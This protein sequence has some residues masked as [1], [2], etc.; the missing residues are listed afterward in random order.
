[1]KRLLTILAAVA[2]IASAVAETR[3]RKSDIDRNIRLFSSVVNQMETNYVDSIDLDNAVETAIA[4]MLDELDPYTEYMPLRAQ[5]SFRSMTTGEYGGIGSYIRSRDGYTYIAGS[6]PGSP[7]MEAGL[8]TGDK[9]VRIDTASTVGWTSDKV[10]ERLKGPAGTRVQVQVIRPWVED[11]LLTFDIIR[12]KIFMPSVPWYGVVSPGVGYIALTSY[13]EQSPREV[14]EALTDL[15]KQGVTG[16]VLDLRG[17]GGGLVES[18]IEIVGMFVPKGTEVLRTR[19]KGVLDEKVYKT[20][21]KP[22][23]PELPLTVLIDGGTASA[24]EITSGA[25]QDLDRAVVLGSRS[26]GKGLVQGTVGL[27]D[28]GLLKVT[29]AKYYIPSGRLIQAIDYSHRNPDGTVARMPDSLTTAYTTA[30]GRTVRDGGGIVPDVTVEYPEINR[31][32]YNVVRDEWDFNYATRYAAEHPEAPALEEFVITDEIYDDFK[33]SIDPKRFEYDK[34]CETILTQLRTAARVEGYM[35]DSVDAQITVLEELMRHPLDHDLD[36]SRSLIEPYLARE[37]MSRY[38]ST[39]GE[40]R[41][42]LRTDPGLKSAL[43]I[44]A[45]PERYRALLRP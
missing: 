45:D 35:T 11:S 31:L 36:V 39:P 27:P 19:G 12:R 9:I 32:T 29:Q 42:T 14:R 17:N 43:G 3:S 1:M 20:T 25:F 16:L 7:A 30:H 10:S 6:Q 22:I 4:A 13:T 44:L 18:A 37:I 8:R 34:V 40:L 5:E 23:A 15:L 21:A 33:R 26:F 2:V 41:T 28:G 38:Y 24:A